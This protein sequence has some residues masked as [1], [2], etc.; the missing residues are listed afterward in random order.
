MRRGFDPAETPKRLTFEQKLS[1]AWAYYVKGVDQHT[2]AALYGVNQ[3]RIATAC[4][5]VELAL[6]EPTKGTD[7]PPQEN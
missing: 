3:G 4:K 7:A 6:T 2:L 1:A 5:A